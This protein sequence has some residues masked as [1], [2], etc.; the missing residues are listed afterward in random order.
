MI[1]ASGAARCTRKVGRV[2]RAQEPQGVRTDGRLT[3]R[4][5]F[6]LSVP[7]GYA[8]PRVR[9]ATYLSNVVVDGVPAPT[10]EGTRRVD[11]ASRDW[12]GASG[13]E[14]NPRPVAYK[15]TALPTELHRHVR[16]ALV[17]LAVGGRACRAG[18]H[19]RSL[20]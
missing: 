6:A 16:L 15:A 5:H 13:V 8:F 18:E 3:V 17:A 11:P 9:Y 14:S 19:F 10:A 4:G 12:I 7:K 1:Y 20:P 2:G